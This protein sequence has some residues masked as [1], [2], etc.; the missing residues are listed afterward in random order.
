MTIPTPADLPDIDTATA[1]VLLRRAQ[2]RMGPAA[3]YHYSGCWREHL[4]CAIIE[5]ERLTKELETLKHEHD[6][7]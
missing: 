1:L 7:A 2:Q 5:V 6:L 4:R 3:S